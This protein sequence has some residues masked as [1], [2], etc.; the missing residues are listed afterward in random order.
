MSGLSFVNAQYMPKILS[1]MCDIG[2]RVAQDCTY[3]PNLQ[4]MCKIALISPIRNVCARFV[5]DCAHF[6]NGQYLHRICAG[7][8]QDCTFFPNAQYM[9][10]I[11]ARLYYICPMCNICARL[12]SI[13]Q[14]ARCVQ[15][16]TFSSI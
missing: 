6:A 2:T 9:C 14:Y 7:F 16:C 13:P 15:D 1:L 10:K 3:F 8:V 4:Y 5:Q 12:H 11:C